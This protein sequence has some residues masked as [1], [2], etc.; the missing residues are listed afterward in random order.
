MKHKKNTK[1]DKKDYFRA[2]LTDTAPSDVPIIFSNDGLYINCHRANGNKNQGFD[3][4]RSLYTNVVS[5]VDNEKH[6]SDEAN[7]RQN[8]QSH[9]LKYKIIKNEHSLRTLSLIHPR[10]QKNHCEFYRD[11]SSVI[12]QLCS[13]SPLSIR[14][15]AKIGGS[16]YTKE[17]DTTNRYKD[18]DIDTLE[19]ELKRRHASSYFAYSGYDRLY[20][21][22]NSP[23][24]VNLEQ[25]F[26]SMWTIDVANCFQSIYTH[27]ISWAIKNKEFVKLHTSYTSQFCQKFD[28]LIQRSNNNETN[29]I[30][31]GSEVSRIF[32]EIIFQD[33]DLK[34]VSSLESKKLKLNDDYVILRYVDDYLIFSHSDENSEII[35]NVIADVIGEY[36]LNLSTSKQV[37]YTRPFCTD[38]SKAI[39]GVKHCLESF[40]GVLLSK[41]NIDGQQRFFPNNIY[42]P[43]KFT[44]NFINNIKSLIWGSER[45]YSDVAAYIVSMLCKRA[46]N[47]ISSHKYNAPHSSDKDLTLRG[48]L[49]III[50]LVFFFYSVA[51]A[52]SSSNKISKTLILTDQFILSTM[53]LHSEFYRT[54]IMAHVNS[55]K[56]NRQKND[57]RNGYLSLERLNILLATSEFGKNHLISPSVFSYLESD[58]AN[59][60]YFDIVSLI[61]YFKDHPQYLSARSSLL[62][63]ALARLTAKP[64][65]QQNSEQAHI[66]LDLI[67]CPYIS[68][69][70]RHILIKD[71]LA[72]YEPARQFSNED[73]VNMVTTL[74]DKFWFV[75]WKNLNLVRLLERKELKPIY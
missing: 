13:K 31:V 20:K 7:Q 56:F 38:K 17:I 55:L 72:V 34:V 22:Y 36:N 29:G 14:C 70:N 4:L 32:A 8:K 2:A 9:P 41:K 74:E 48:A 75:K 65:L 66:F 49:L 67:C 15:P 33:T 37:K 10:S 71:Y 21:L 11:H 3:I 19:S 68:A 61:Y 64:N 50:R 45:G 35:S 58:E 25:R 16:F 59:V 62:Q 53:P 69:E 27:T 51:P 30:P 43:T 60:T 26:A 57:T 46:E 5:P 23:R 73:V 42:S 6:D 44:Q 54:E 18:I 52:I 63:I 1:I 39:L 12:I 28:T 47:L 24:Y 40:E